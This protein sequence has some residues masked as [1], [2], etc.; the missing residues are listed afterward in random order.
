MAFALSQRASHS[1]ESY[2]LSEPQG[3]ATSLLPYLLDSLEKPL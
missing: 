2:Q 3:Q 1:M